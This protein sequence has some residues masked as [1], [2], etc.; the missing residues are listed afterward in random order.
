MDTGPCS[1]LPI[2]YNTLDR[3][4]HL[5]LE[6][7]RGAQVHTR[8]K[9]VEEGNSSTLYFLR[10]E[11]K[12]SADRNVSP[13]RAE[14]GFLVSDKDGL[15]DTFHSFYL[16]LFT[17]ALCDSLARAELLSHVSSV[18]P[19]DQRDLC[20]GL[21]SQEECLM[22]LKCMARGKAPGCDRLP[23]EFYLKFWTVLGSDLVDVLNFAYASDRLSSC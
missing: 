5:D 18:L 7:A 8:G 22:A 20:E 4:K 21:L 10:L 2:Y 6:D 3:I 19:S 15:C 9:W 16:N 1:L 12:H 11:R 17:A 23:M 14:D 13:L